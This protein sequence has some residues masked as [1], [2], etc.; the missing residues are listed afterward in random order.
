MS[1]HVSVDLK[2]KTPESWNCIDCGVNTAPGYPSRIEMERLYNTSVAITKLSG[3][4]VPVARLEFNDRCEVYSVRNTVWKAA[5]MEPMGGCLCIGCLE[6][7]IGR[8]LKSKDFPRNHPF[9]WVPGSARL[10]ERRGQ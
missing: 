4:D 2:G 7:R 1:D 3:E 9:N 10:M 6:K 8:R 5:G